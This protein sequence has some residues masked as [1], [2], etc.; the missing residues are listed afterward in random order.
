MALQLLPNVT[1]D[2]EAVETATGL[3]RLAI[4]PGPAGRYRLAQ[5]DDYHR[6]PRRAFSW[7]APLSLS[8][9]ARA[10]HESLPGTW[11]FGLWN[12]PFGL[13]FLQG[14]G[15]RLPALPNTAWFF[16]ASPPNYLSL[17]DDLPAA[18]ALAMTFRSPGWHSILFLPTILL[19]PLLLAR[20]LVRGIR[21]LARRVVQQDAVAL[22][23]NPVERHNYRI[24]WDIDRTTFYVDG[25][26]VLETI[27]VPAGPLGLVIWLDNQ[28]AAIPP[29]G[30][31]GYGTLPNQQ[32][33]WIEIEDVIIKQTGA[34]FNPPRQDGSDPPL[35]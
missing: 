4:S 1:S 25:K 9:S 26:L 21:R 17:R 15:V 33:S 3:W 13:A 6:V 14:G 12:D 29:D 32:P 16:F 24:D 35:T 31:L 11:G 10:S 18:G 27:V 5:L 2:G 7:H 22:T 34:E 30:R 23:T 19:T 28:Y 8:L 20:P